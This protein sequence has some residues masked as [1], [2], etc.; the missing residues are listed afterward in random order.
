VWSW[1]KR[2]CNRSAFLAKSLEISGNVASFATWQAARGLGS[3]GLYG[4][5][6]RL[7]QAASA[8]LRT[9]KVTVL[10][11]GVAAGDATRFWLSAVPNPELQWHGFDT[12]TGLPQPWIR[13]GIRFA[14]PGT[15][16]AGGSPPNIPD[17]R[18]IWHVGP[19][20]ETLPAAAIDF[21]TP[22]C[23]LFDLDL[24]EPSA[25][26]LEWLAG[27]F[28]AG[29]LLYF[30]Q[31]YDPWHERHLLDEFFDRGHRVRAIGSTG[32]ALM[33]EYEGPPPG[34]GHGQ[35]R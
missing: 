8:S 25:F 26:A 9:G 34:H 4:T 27:H 33:L 19:V 18:L 28:K 6:E 32:I 14:E 23:V 5:R 3:G 22:L 29:D 2:T 15:F 24:Y 7:W 30:D 11:L 35:A 12:F 20:E 16:D 1:L 13:G 10:E 31:A 17:P 21:E